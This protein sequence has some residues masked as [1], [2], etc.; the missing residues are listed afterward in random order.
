LDYFISKIKQWLLKDKLS[1]AEVGQRAL[2]SDYRAHQTISLLNQWDYKIPVIESEAAE[3]TCTDEEYS[4]LV[5]KREEKIKSES[6][7]EPVDET[8]ARVTMMKPG[9]LLPPAQIVLNPDEDEHTAHLIK[10][11]PIRE[12]EEFTQESMEN[13]K[14]IAARIARYN[15][16]GYKLFEEEQEDEL[17]KNPQTP[18]DEKEWRYHSLQ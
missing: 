16:I 15:E 6:V 9:D 4:A 14:R 12:S 2:K 3:L 8:P 1:W 17:K 11:L 13:A 10:T 7:P 18:L 5:E